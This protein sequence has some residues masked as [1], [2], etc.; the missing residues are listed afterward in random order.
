M[1]PSGSRTGRRRGSPSPV[2]LTVNGG[3]VEVDDQATGT[4]AAQ[5]IREPT[6]APLGG[7]R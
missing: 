5:E 3:E 2:Q 7:S 1:C 6:E 4:Q